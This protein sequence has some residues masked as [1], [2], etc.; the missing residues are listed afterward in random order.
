MRAK[1]YKCCNVKCGSCVAHSMCGEPGDAALSCTN[2]IVWKKTNADRIRAMSNE[3]LAEFFCPE[4]NGNSPWCSPVGKTRCGKAPCKKC[5]LKWL[6]QPA[7][8][9]EHDQTDG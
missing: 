2:R 1:G 7:K 6:L 4:T 8:E 5:M 3:E 9:R